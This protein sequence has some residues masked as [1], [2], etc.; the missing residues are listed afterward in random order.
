MIQERGAVDQVDAEF[1][2]FGVGARVL[3]VHLFTD[4]KH[5]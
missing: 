5:R 3:A 2:A 4:A 1:L